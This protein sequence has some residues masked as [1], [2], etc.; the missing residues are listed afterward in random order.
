MKA[1]I[2]KLTEAYAPS[3]FEHAVRE[4]IEA[5]L[6]DI[7]D[8]IT[9]DALGNLHAVKKSTGGSPNGELTIMLAAHMDEIG[10]M[11]SFIDDEGFARIVPLGGVASD[12]LIGS[13]VTFTN[14]AVGVIGVENWILHDRKDLMRKLF[15]D[16]G[17]NGKDKVPVR[18]GDVAGFQRPFVDLGDILLAKSLDDRIGCAI[19]I[20]TLKQIEETP[21]ELH[22]VFTIQEELG[23][24][25]PKGAATAAYKVNP[26]VAIA[27][28]VTDSGDIPGRKHY[29]VKMGHGPAIKVRDGGMLAHPRLKQWMVKTATKQAIPYQLEIMMLGTTD[30]QAMQRVHAG[31]IAG[32]LSVPCRHV[33]TPSEMVNYQDVEHCVQLLVAMLSAPAELDG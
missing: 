25:P 30:A 10:V 32:A 16:F 9:V 27:V 11:V 15:V 19:L 22:F 6:A 26:D 29:D 28:D 31:S 2:K 4:I 20:E 8:E 33:H 17:V 18:I 23:G 24:G 21:H 7:A 3:G 1:L 5:E 12:T 14:G 13:R